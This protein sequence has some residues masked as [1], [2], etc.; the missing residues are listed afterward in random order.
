LARAKVKEIVE[1]GRVKALYR[2]P[3]KSMH[4]QNLEE[5]QVG[6]HGLTGDRRYAFVKTGNK[7][8]FP[9]LTGREIPTILQYVPSFT[10]PSDPTESAIMVQTP[11]GLTKHIEDEE[12]LN[13]LQNMYGKAAHLVQSNRG[14]FDSMTISMVTTSTLKALS[15]KLE[16]ELDGRQFRQNIVIENLDGEPFAEESWLGGVLLFGEE[17]EPVRVRANR[18]IKRCVMINLNPDTAEKNPAVL[19]EVAQNRDNCLGIFGTTQEPGLVRVGDLVR[20]IKK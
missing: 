4:A 14:N 5:V 6:W 20:Y 1:I 3:V 19:R 12:L 7:S 18:Q 11:A 10:D 16:T 15:E 17:A 9:W 8:H 13:E 2:Y